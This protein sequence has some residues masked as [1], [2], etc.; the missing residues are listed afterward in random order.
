MRLLS[1]IT[2][3]MALYLEVDATAADAAGDALWW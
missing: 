2:E 1:P 3:F